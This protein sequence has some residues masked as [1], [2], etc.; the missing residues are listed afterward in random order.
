MTVDLIVK[1]ADFT[2]RMDVVNK[3]LGS[4]EIDIKGGCG[5]LSV[6]GEELHLIVQD[7]VNARRVLQAADITISDERKVAVII[8]DLRGNTYMDLNGVVEAGSN[9]YILKVPDDGAARVTINIQAKDE[10]DNGQ[11]AKGCSGIFTSVFK[12]MLGG[13]KE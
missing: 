11:D 9:I 1:I 10:G 13:K 6:S 5:F 7:A 3:V 12:Q 2:D 4:S 8:S